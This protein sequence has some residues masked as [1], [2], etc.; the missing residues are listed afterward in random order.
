MIQVAFV[1]A[2]NLCDVRC[3]SIKYMIQL[4]GV[5][6]T[7]MTTWEFTGAKSRAEL[8]GTRTCTNPKRK[9]DWICRSLLARHKPVFYPEEGASASVRNISN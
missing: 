3:L 9:L 5:G 6:M 4:D 1:N 2:V 7:V 8:G